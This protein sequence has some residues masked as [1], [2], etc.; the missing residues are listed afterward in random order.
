MLRGK[1]RVW[2]S[3]ALAMTTFLGSCYIYGTLEQ[4]HVLQTHFLL[5]KFLAAGDGE[6]AYSLTTSDYRANHTLQEFQ[7]EFV[8][9]K[10]QSISDVKDPLVLSCC[11]F[12]TAEIYAWES[13]GMFEFLNGPSFHYRKENGQWR[14]TGETNHYLD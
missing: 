14:F 1:K 5:M 9:Y 3:F 11:S 2:L 10:G 7:T 8:Y 6:R 13:P 4:K 12:G